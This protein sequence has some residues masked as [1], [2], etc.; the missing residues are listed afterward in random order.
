M[1]LRKVGT[2]LKQH[3]LTEGAREQA[4]MNL[5]ASER[6]ATKLIYI[7][8]GHDMRSLG[9]DQSNYSLALA[10]SGEVCC[11]TNTSKFFGRK[12]SG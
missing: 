9:N 4:P 2:A 8:S 7:A 12:Q 3:G 1:S 11:L 5:S 6:Q 10:F